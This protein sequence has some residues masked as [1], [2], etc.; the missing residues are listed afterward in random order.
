[1]AENTITLNIDGHDVT[2]PHGSTIMEA[3]NKLAIEVPRFCY[4]KRLSVAGNC[5]M[6][7]VEVEGGPPKPIASC[8]WP[9]ADGM[10]VR[11]DTEMVTEARK[12]T[13][14]FLLV[15][16]PLDCPECDQGGECDLQDISVSYGSDVSRFKETKHVTA[17]LDIGPKIETVMTRCINC[18]RCVR[19]ATEVAG[20]EEFGQT[21]RGVNSTIGTYVENALQSELAGNMIDLC[22]VGA[23]TSK[24]YKFAGRPWEL[25][26]TPSVDVMD[27][28][29][30]NIE[31]H[32]RAGKVMRIVPRENEAVNEEWISDTARFSYDGLYENRLTSPMLKQGRGLKTTSWDNAF[33]KVKAALKGKKEVAGIASG[34]HCAEDYFAFNAFMKDV[35]K[36]DNVD[37]RPV[38]SPLTSG[39]RTHYIMNSGITGVDEADAILFVGCNPRLEAPVL[40]ARVRGNVLK[41]GV[42]VYSVGAEM[43]LTYGYEN[44]GESPAVLEKLAKPASKFAKEFKKAENPMIIVG[45][46]AGLNRKDGTAILSNLHAMAEKLGVIRG[47][48]NGMNVLQNEAGSVTAL[49]MQVHPMEKG[50]NTAKI[51]KAADDKKIDVLFIYGDM[52]LP[53]EKLKN[54][55]TV[56]YI[57]THNSEMAKIADIALPAAAYTEKAGLW[58]NTEGR[59]QESKIS[60]PPMLNAKEDW[61]VFRALS[62]VLGKELPFN[63]QNQ[64]REQIYNLVPQYNIF[65]DEE[66]LEEKK[67]ELFTSKTKLAARNFAQPVKDFYLSNEILRASQTMHE[68]QSAVNGKWQASN[69]PR[70]QALEYKRFG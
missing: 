29:G 51:V 57:G 16:H 43:D 48:W 15:N 31:V 42:K 18:T 59:V 40:N 67:P 56:I 30:S 44:L 13:M 1:M 26:R 17:D 70:W 10:V 66:I 5:R 27:A 6:C 32:S 9:A 61:K 12:G 54:A 52:D 14:E 50:K 38:D 36:T 37:A 22:P 2:V 64:L 58:T 35:I 41:R 47:N 49:D 65:S 24:P 23:L 33:K 34:V 45:A 20:V 8:A 46:K 69:D 7:L 25:K 28:L 3:A 62:G 68:C 11:T 4:H 63:S 19:F 53:A 60:V 21:G 39:D 55:K